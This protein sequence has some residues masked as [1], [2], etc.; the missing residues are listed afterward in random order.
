[1]FCCY[2]FCSTTF[3]NNNN[4]NTNNNNNNNNGDDI[5]GA[6]IMAKPLRELPSSFD[7]CRLS[8]SWPPTLK[9]SQLTWTKSAVNGSYHP[10][11]PSPFIITQP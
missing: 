10:H 3:N 9:L 8:A 6:V 11:P 2:R 7:E 4:N 1:M 5:Y